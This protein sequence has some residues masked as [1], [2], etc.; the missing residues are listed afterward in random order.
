MFIQGEPLPLAFWN[1]SDTIN[2]R[3][4]KKILQEVWLV[5]QIC[6]YQ[7]GAQMNS[8]M[9]LMEIGYQL[10]YCW[11]LSDIAVTEFEFRS[12]SEM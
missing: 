10:M 3:S 6:S 5:Q 12:L 8:R 1:R 9:N 4:M 2:V 11:R 7:N